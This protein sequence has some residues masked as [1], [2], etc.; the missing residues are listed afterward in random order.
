MGV[1]MDY[2]WDILAGFIFIAVLAYIA[3]RVNLEARRL[4]LSSST[5]R[6]ATF[7]CYFPPIIGIPFARLLLACRE[8]HLS[9]RFWSTTLIACW[10][11]P[12]GPIAWFVAF[13]L[14]LDN[15]KKAAA[16]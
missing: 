4:G 2:F 16:K 11:F 5:R 14:A 12:L 8:Y 15:A 6:A 3:C 13:F 7:L 9:F 1:K 10:L